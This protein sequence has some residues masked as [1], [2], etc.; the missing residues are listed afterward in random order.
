[1][2]FEIGA[3]RV[4]HGDLMDESFHEL[5]IPPVDIIYSDPPWGQGNLNYWQTL[6]AKMNGAEKRSIDY[7]AFIE[8]V[9]GVA[10][11][12]TKNLFFLEYGVRWRSDIKR[13]GEKFNFVDNGTI[14]TRYKSG[15]KFYPLDLHVFSKIPVELSCPYLD[16]VAG[17]RGYSTIQAAVKPFVVKGGALLDPCCGM[18]Y[19]AKIAKDNGMIFYGNELN[20][21]RLNKTIKRLEK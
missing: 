19:S 3:H 5:N 11:I 16:S 1:M 6:N 20:L 4:R 8:R 10:A 12:Y 9:F 14:K 13:L 17:T 21:K 2:I 18:G 7:G 15:S